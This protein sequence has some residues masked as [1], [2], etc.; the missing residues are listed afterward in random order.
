MSDSH[1]LFNLKNKVWP[2]GKEIE[3]VNQHY[4]NFWSCSVHTFCSLSVL[5]KSCTVMGKDQRWE[6]TREPSRWKAPGANTNTRFIRDRSGR[7]IHQVLSHSCSL[8]VTHWATVAFYLTITKRGHLESEWVSPMCSDFKTSCTWSAS[9][10]SC[11]FSAS[12]IVTVYLVFPSL[13][14]LRHIFHFIFVWYKQRY[15]I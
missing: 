6:L 2:T 10:T 1:G 12:W 8:P 11:L 15:I 13:S 9:W 3:W 5:H 14:L 7:R 4:L